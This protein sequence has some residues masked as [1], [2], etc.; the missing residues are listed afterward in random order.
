M[1]DT[2]QNLTETLGDT[3]GD[4]QE[5]TTETLFDTMGTPGEYNKNTW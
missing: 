5:D 4:T 2:H 3:M 1:R